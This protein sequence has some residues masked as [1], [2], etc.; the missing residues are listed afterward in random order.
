MQG[1]GGPAVSWRGGGDGGMKLGSGGE[2]VIF[3]LLTKEKS[4][5]GD[6]LG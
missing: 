4:V 3:A 1:G 6:D 2:L 5:H